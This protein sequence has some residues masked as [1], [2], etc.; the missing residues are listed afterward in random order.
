M[1]NEALIFQHV[2]IIFIHTVKIQVRCQPDTCPETK[3]RAQPLSIC[4]CKQVWNYTYRQP[5]LFNL[6]MCRFPGCM[7]YLTVMKIT[8]ETVY[9]LHHHLYYNVTTKSRLYNL[10]QLH[11]TM[12]ALSYTSQTNYTRLKLSHI[13]MYTRWLYRYRHLVYMC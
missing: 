13:H 1:T 4:A 7:V 6:H 11:Y 3:N 5:R 8:T 2:Y 9:W 12:Y 10:G